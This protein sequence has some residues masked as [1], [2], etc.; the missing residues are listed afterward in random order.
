MAVIENDYQYKATQFSNG[1]VVNEAGT[2]EGSCKL[3]AFAKLNHLGEQQTLALFGQYYRDD[4]MANPE[5][6]DHAN[7]RNFMVSGWQ[8]IEF[9]A[10]A[11]TKK[12]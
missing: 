6:T 9:S 11:L 4:V 12:S 2:N 3:F 10:L 5:G 8:G 1:D 7:I